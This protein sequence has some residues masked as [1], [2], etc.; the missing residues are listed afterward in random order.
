MALAGVKS[1]EQDI[2]TGITI[3]R[4]ALEEP[5][6]H[7]ASN[8]GQDRAVV[9]D[10]MRCMAK[11]LKN[12]NIGFNVMS[13]EYEDMVRCGIIDPAKVTCSAAATQSRCAF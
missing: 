4:R 3:M 12:K 1:E 5:M 6:R 13:G 9:M 2:Q 8:V 7:F 11:E 10:T